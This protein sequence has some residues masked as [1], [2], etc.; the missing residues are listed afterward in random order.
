M[1]I[2]G[3]IPARQESSRFPGKP[4]ADICGKPM[5]W[6]VYMQAAQVEEFDEVI[7]A[8]DDE[9]IF[10]VCKSLGIN[11]LMTS[12][13][14][15]TGTDRTVEVSEKIKGD[16]YIVVMGDEPLISPDNIR[17]MLYAMLSD[18]KYDAG[19]LCTKFKNGVDVINTST[20]KLAVNNQSE[21][22]YMSRLPIPFPKSS[23]NYNHYKNVGVYAYTKNTLNFFRNTARGKLEEIED[24]EMLRMLEHHKLV[25]VVEV[26]TESMSIDTPK[27]LARIRV[28]A[29]DKIKRRELPP[30][31]ISKISAVTTPPRRNNLIAAYCIH[32]CFYKNRSTKMMALSAAVYFKNLM[33]LISVHCLI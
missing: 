28:I 3:V 16:L 5:V 9:N 32:P 8:T 20:I 33:M 14:H 13:H 1:K 31:F 23:L 29:A 6:W 10:N 26:T 18:K 30:A 7:V 4:L 15:P 19:M 27:D 12:K 17:A 24:M 11:V 22:I 2:I 25:K 21:L